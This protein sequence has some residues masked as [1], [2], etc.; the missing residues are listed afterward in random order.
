MYRYYFAPKETLLPSYEIL[1]FGYDWTHPMVELGLKEAKDVIAMGPGK[2]FD[3]LHNEHMK[4][5]P[6]R[7]QTEL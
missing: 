6:E 3:H 1:E 4:L 2:S 7:Y 5:F